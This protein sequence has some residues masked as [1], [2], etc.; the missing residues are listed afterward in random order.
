LRR[1]Y[2][3]RCS[4]AEPS[5]HSDAPGLLNFACAYDESGSRF[6]RFK[7]IEFP[8]AICAMRN[9]DSPKLPEKEHCC[10]SAYLVITLLTPFSYSERRVATVVPQYFRG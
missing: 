6:T 10:S 3:N 4:A 7:K 8:G 5:T 2:H 9:L 1:A